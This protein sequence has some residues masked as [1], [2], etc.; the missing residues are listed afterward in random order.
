[1]A[2]ASA[3]QATTAA[4]QLGTAASV[5]PAPAE[6]SGASWRGLEVALGDVSALR[7]V[8]GDAAGGRLTAIMGATGAGK[9]TLLRCLAGRQAHQGTV[10]Y[11]TAAGRTLAWTQSLRHKVAFVEQD[12][13]V[14]PVLTVRETLGYMARLRLSRLSEE[15]CSARVE[16]IIQTL[17]LTKCADTQCGD[18]LKR[19]ISGGE[20]KRL[21][22]AQEMLTDPYVLLCDEPTSGLDSTTA[23]VCVEALRDLAR[24]RG[25]AVLC[26]VMQPSSQVFDVFDDLMVMHKGRIF[27]HGPVSEVAAAFTAATDLSCPS[28]VAI[29]DWFIDLIVNERIPVPACERMLAAAA[30]ACPGT[31]DGPAQ[32]VSESTAERHA[33]WA[34]Q[35]DVLFR[36]HGTIFR[37]SLWPWPWSQTA[38]H[39][40]N[41]IIEGVIWWQLQPKE[42]DLFSFQTAVFAI[43]VTWM[44]F[45][46]S[47]SVHMWVADEAV[48][49]RERA[50]GAYR[51]SVWYAAA[52]TFHLAKECIWPIIFHPILFWMA[53]IGGWDVFWAL[54]ALVLL[55][56]AVFQAAGSALGAGFPPAQVGTACMVFIFF[57]FLFL[58]VFKPMSLTEFPWLRWA[59]PTW[60][61]HQLGVRLSTPADVIYECADTTAGQPTSFPHKCPGGNIT[62]D[63]IFTLYEVH[64]PAA[65]SW[66][67]L[68]GLFVVLRVTAFLLIRRRLS[69]PA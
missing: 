41:G 15:E 17:R 53:G 31:H 68:C 6:R 32:T 44:F 51:V 35:A 14:W 66:A 67:V 61:A 33:G 54:L 65:V 12:D 23:L 34:R 39:V 11:T 48:V 42:Q 55:V 59:N 57:N 47:A 64:V 50:V 21:C 22:V 29:P 36:R 60:Y 4:A 43:I 26:S 2:Q 18:A 38:L 25:I 58:G 46:L 63:D 16:R 27:Y 7:G 13:L 52:T 62:R 19:G 9:T 8:C 49:R 30:A 40:G 45:P 10:R 69:K 3:E 5:A 37:R 20:R 56:T 1:M 28:G 24:D